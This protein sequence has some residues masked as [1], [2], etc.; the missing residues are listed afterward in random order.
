M[1]VFEVDPGFGVNIA[2]HLILPALAEALI[3]MIFNE[4][5]GL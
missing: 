1:P 2:R 3:I 4:L 5:E